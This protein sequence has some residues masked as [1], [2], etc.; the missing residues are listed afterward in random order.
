MLRKNIYIVGLYYIKWNGVYDDVLFICVGDFINC[1]E[2]FISI[3]SDSF[4]EIID[5][6]MI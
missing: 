3:I 2:L 1:L 4:S 6:I 5:M